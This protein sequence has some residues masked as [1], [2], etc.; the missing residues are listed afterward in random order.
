MGYTEKEIHE[1]AV[2]LVEGGH[3]W[4]EGHV[5]GARI[6]NEDDNPCMVCA[7]D[8]IC[9]MQ[10]TDLC[11]ECDTISRKRHFLYLCAHN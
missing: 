6:C 7:M 9:S 8:S 5:I 10:M 2:R 3:V 11:D 1:K 4:F